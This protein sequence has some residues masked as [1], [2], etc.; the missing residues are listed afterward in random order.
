MNISAGFT[1]IETMVAVSLL[2]VAIVAPMALAAQS[3]ASAYY[4]RDQVTAFYLAQEGIESVRSVRDGNILRDSQGAGVNLLN[5]IPTGVP[6][7]IDTRTNQTWTTCTTNPLKTDGAFYGYGTDPCITNDP[8]WTATYF[9]RTLTACFVQ[10]SGACD[11]SGAT[12]EITLTSTVTWSSGGFSQRSVTI[13]EN[14]YR[15]VDDGSAAI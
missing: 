7:V 14:L 5:G 15:W 2:S 8:G 13:S 12:D 9:R 10:A 11:N 6:F 4:A 1:L 3:L